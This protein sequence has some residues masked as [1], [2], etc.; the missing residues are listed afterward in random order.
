[1]LT[2]DVAG[3]IILSTNSTGRIGE[4]TSDVEGACNAVKDV[5]AERRKPSGEFS[6][7][8]LVPVAAER[9]FS[10]ESAR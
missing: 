3:R 10:G 9:G 5:V 6:R 1:M 8:N 2:D 4:Q 7:R